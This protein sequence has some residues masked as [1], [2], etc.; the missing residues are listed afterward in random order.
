[1]RA[2]LA[3]SFLFACEPS[4]SQR[5]EI[6]PPVSPAEPA[7][8]TDAASGSCPAAP[9]WRSERIA[10]PPDFAPTMPRGTEYLWFAPG[11]FDPDSDLF[12]T[13]VIAFEF[14][15]SVT[16]DRAS[17]D[18]LFS[19]YFEGLM[20]SVAA[21]TGKGATRL[22]TTVSSRREDGTWRV[23]VDTVDAFVTGAPL[24]LELVLDRGAG[25][26]TDCLVARVQPWGATDQSEALERA[27]S[28]LPC[29]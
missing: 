8:A 28:C 21:Q 10:L 3:L 1:M 12:F 24:S 13:Y 25:E 11:M 6:E 18:S 15:D 14:E 2:L 26:R 27:R 29:R 7:D 4:R 16:L 17:L 23:R 9:Q 19:T 22:E 20:T 5:P